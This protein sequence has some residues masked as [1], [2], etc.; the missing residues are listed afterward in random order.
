MES[1]RN[2]EVRNHKN[3]IIYH[4]VV[5]VHSLDVATHDTKMVLVWLWKSV[6]NF[7]G[8]PEHYSIRIQYMSIIQRKS[9]LKT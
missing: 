3:K 6:S 7:Y 1:Y 2:C 8:N 5:F 9:S 4:C